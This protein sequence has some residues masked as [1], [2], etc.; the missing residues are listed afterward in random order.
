MNKV[1]IQ[2]AAH[3]SAQKPLSE[4]WMDNPV[5]YEGDS[6]K[7]I[8][9]N[10]KEYLAPNVARRMGKLL[11][12]ALV[13]A[14]MAMK[15]AKVEMPDAIIT[16]TGLGCIEN[17]EHFLDAMTREGE[18]LLNPTPFM[19]STHNTIGSSIALDIKCHGYN[20]H[21]SQKHTSFDCALQDAFIQFQNGK[22]QT[23]LLNAHDESSSVFDSILQH[24][25][26]WHFENGGFK[27][28]TAISMALGNQPTPETLCRMEDMMICYRPTMPVL[29]KELQKLLERNGLTIHDLD[30][31]F[32]GVNGNAENDNVYY[33][34][35]ETLFPNLPLARYKHLFGEHFT[36]SGI[37]FYVVAT[38]LQQG[39][40]PEH[41]L[42]A[43]ENPAKQV[44]CIVLYNHS[45]NRDHSMILL[46]NKK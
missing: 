11:K 21:Y 1:Y 30:A 22:I 46:S 39:R 2:S 33:A 3:I 40:L 42:L 6:V 12:R 5:V 28:E 41:L 27:G 38:C 15:R 9:L 45:E 10:Y 34:C 13:C 37:G 32:I 19:Q 25:D 7:S 36:M 14:R 44:K 43:K 17:T 23:A 24:I 4:E 20:S 8:D 35:T 29:Q 26:C 18:T 31:V 16:A